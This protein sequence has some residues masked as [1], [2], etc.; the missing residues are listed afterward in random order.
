MPATS[1]T[2]LLTGG[3]SFLL[4]LMVLSYLIGDNPAF[5][6]AI[7]LFVGVSAGYAASVAWHQVLVARLFV[8]LLSGST[9]ERLLSVIPLVLGALLLLK[10]SPLTSP[11]GMPSMAYLVGVAAAV[12]IGGSVMGT[13]LPQAIASITAFHLDGGSYPWL[14]HLVE[15]LIMLIGTASA[16]A[17]FHF[18]KKPSSGKTRLGSFGNVLNWVG[19][20]FIA[21]TF[22]A[23]FAGV[24]VAALSA[25]VERMSFII[26]YLSSF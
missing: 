17:Y 11:L 4:T 1:F 26:S 21:I 19:R 22:G 15:A 14:G 20:G 3:I 9:G 5:R 7:Y 25:L 10:I 24:L 23:L 6:V 13:L 16:L 2:D 8:P 18:G 12:A